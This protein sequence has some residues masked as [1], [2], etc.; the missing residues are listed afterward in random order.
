[1]A[2][3]P[4]PQSVLPPQLDPRK[5][6][7]QALQVEGYIAVSSLHR[8]CEI[9]LD[10]EGMV[11][12]RLA[13][14]VDGDRRLRIRGHVSTEV[15]VVCQRC[16]LPMTQTLED[17][18]DLVMVNSDAQMKQLPS[19]LDPWFCG[20]DDVLIP[21]D[22]VEEQL[23]LAM[24]IVTMHASCVDIDELAGKAQ[25]V[26]VNGQHKKVPPGTDSSGSDPDK[27]NPFA[28]LA[29]LKSDRKS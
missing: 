9:L 6:F 13:F 27:H 15:S 3:T 1:M 25:A 16:M 22:I 23:I 10:N 5:V 2:E 26:P 17:A 19:A 8:L 28:V 7:R 18:I 21:A 29:G 4:N 24:P 20:E 12:A 14:E 11:A